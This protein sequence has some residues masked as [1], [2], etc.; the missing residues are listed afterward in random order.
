MYGQA[1]RRLGRTL[2]GRR[3][4]VF[5]ATKIWTSSLEEGRAQFEAQL[6]YYGGRIE[7]E[8]VHNLVAWETQLGWLEREHADGRVAHLGATHYSPSAFG[9]LERVMRSGRIH[10]VQ[11]PYNPH[12]REAEARIL[13]LAEE[14]GLGVIVMRPLGEG[15]LLPGPP[16]EDLRPLGVDTWAEALLKW[17]LSDPRVTLAIPATRNPEH[18]RENARAGSR[19]SLDADQRK[20]VERLAR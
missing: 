18:A 8:Q 13:P 14:L 15:G 20:L 5:V 3:E 1:E 11:I 4:S 9:E 16:P 19:P 2:E 10:A 17:C 6:D 7:L 12:E